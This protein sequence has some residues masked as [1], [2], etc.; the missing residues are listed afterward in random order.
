MA[1]A[2][3]STDKLPVLIKFGNSSPPI[4]DNEKVAR[5]RACQ[6]VGIVQFRVRTIAEDSQ[7][8]T[9]VRKVLDAIVEGINDVDLV[10]VPDDAAVSDG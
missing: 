8:V 1:S 2:P 4:F 7:V 3:H 6:I 9:R 10:I 5:G